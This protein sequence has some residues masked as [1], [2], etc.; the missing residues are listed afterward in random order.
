MTTY[1]R[2]KTYA[3]SL[4]IGIVIGFL[5]LLLGELHKLEVGLTSTVVTAQA[6]LDSLK[7]VGPQAV[8][9]LKSVDATVKSVGKQATTSLKVS[10]KVGVVLDKAAQTLDGVNR[11]CA[12]TASDEGFVASRDGDKHPMKPCGTLADVNRTLASVRGTV[13]QIEVAARHENRNL[14]T[15]DEQEK[16]VVAD[17][18]TTTTNF[19]ALVASPDVQRFLKAS[20]DTSVQVAAIATDVH[21]EA[22]A[23]VKPQP[24][25]RKLY[26]YGS[27]GVNVACLVTHS[28]PF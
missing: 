21:K 7:G 13:G 20:A 2:F 23:L 27:T 10:T 1:E 8:S 22:D 6:T 17:L 26:N 16:Q 28:C 25:Y 18:H 12:V 3:I 4:C 11:P 15:L 5:T 24:W 14:D 19:N 9:T